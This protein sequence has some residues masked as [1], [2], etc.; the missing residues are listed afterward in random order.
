MG[1]FFHSAFQIEGKI[2]S[3][4]PQRR[5]KHYNATPECSLWI[6]PMLMD[7]VEMAPAQSHL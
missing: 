5:N 7:N 4:H 6:A 2:V 3:L 1:F